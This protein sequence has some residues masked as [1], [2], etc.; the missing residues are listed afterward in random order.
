MGLTKTAPQWPLRTPIFY[1]NASQFL[2]PSFCLYINISL[3]IEIDQQITL[4]TGMV[5]L[6]YSLK[7]DDTVG[8]C[9]LLC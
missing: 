5:D 7:A 2:M 8:I 1:C 9:S 4:L 3:A 6:G